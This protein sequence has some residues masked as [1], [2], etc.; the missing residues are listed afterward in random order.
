MRRS[1]LTEK[2]TRRGRHVLKEYS[3][4]PLEFSQLR[5][6]MTANAGHRSYPV[7]RRVVGILPRQH[8]LK[9]RSAHRHAEAQKARFMGL[10]LRPDS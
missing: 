5:Q 2:I 10:N 1:I 7:T 6:L 3:V 4:G 9:A 8:V